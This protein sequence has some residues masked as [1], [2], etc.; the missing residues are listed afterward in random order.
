MRVFLDLSSAESECASGGQ[1]AGIRDTPT[2]FVWSQRDRDKYC[3]GLLGH[4]S[5]VIVEQRERCMTGC[6]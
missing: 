4:R 1:F 5:D 2:K 6:I 3:D